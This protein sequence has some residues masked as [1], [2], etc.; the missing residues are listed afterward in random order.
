M[1]SAAR[2]ASQ[3][4]R[5]LPGEKPDALGIVSHYDSHPTPPARQ[6]MRSALRRRWRRLVC[7]PRRAGRA[8]TLLRLITDGEEAGLMGAA[9]LVTDRDGDRP[10]ARLPQ[11]RIDRV[12]RGTSV[13]FETGPGNGWLVS[14]G[15]AAR[16]I[17][18]ASYA[19]EV[20]TRPPNDTDF[21]IFKATDVPGL[22]FAAVGDSYA[23]HTA[24]DTPNGCRAKQCGRPARTLSPS[25]RRC[26]RPTSLRE[27][28]T[29]RCSSTSAAP[30][31]SA[32]ARPCTGRSRRWR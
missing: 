30:L 15:R 18:A 19:I 5:S 13:L 20:Y 6:T 14:R 24:R 11:S 7:S 1:S 3:H 23:Y 27:Q 16:R 29:H 10:P 12:A 8:R 32:T 22:N 25:R 21:S 31:P 28:P 9:A 17:R 2:R 26:R 4:H